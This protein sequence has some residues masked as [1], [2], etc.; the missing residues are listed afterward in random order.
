MTKGSPHTLVCAEY[1]REQGCTPKGQVEKGHTG[2]TPGNDKVGGGTLLAT[3]E[4]Q[5][6]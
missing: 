4:S 1:K 2:Q 5:A 3:C 6:G